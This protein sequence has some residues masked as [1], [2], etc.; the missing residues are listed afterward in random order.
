MSTPPFALSLTWADLDELIADLG[1][2]PFRDASKVMDWLNRKLEHHNREVARVRAE[3]D[4]E[5]RAAG[6]EPP[7]QSFFD[8]L[9]PLPVRGADDKLH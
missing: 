7:K 8:A 2:I 6:I 1:D 5:L 3:I 4:A 9:E